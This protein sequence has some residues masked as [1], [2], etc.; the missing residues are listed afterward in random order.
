MKGLFEEHSKAGNP[1]TAG[2]E[3]DLYCNREATAPDWTLQGPVGL[4]IWSL[5]KFRAVIDQEGLVHHPCMPP[6]EI[7]RC[8]KQELKARI[9]RMGTFAILLEAQHRR[10]PM[11]D[12]AWCDHVSWRSACNAPNT[13]DL[14]LLTVAV[15]GAAW[16]GSPLCHAGARPE[17][18]CPL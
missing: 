15:R 16:N 6:F 11:E 8:P 13:E 3:G 9:E 4:V 12:I 14:G 7:F 2:A 18:G 1:G 10:P 17:P 5:N